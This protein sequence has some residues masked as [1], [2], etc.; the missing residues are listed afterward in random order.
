MKRVYDFLARLQENNN[1]EWFNLHKEEYIEAQTIFNDFTQKLIDAISRW[2]DEIR[3]SALTVKDCTYRIYRDTRFSKNK[4]PYKTHMGAYICK[5]GKKSPYAGYYFHLEP[6]SRQVGFAGFLGG[7]LLAAGLYC[8]DAKVIESIRDEISVNGDSFLDAIEE[9]GGFQLE[10]YSTLKRIPKGYENIEERWKELIKHKDFSIAEPLP[11]DM[12]ASGKLLEH[13][14][15]RFQKCQKFNS[16]LNLAVDY[17]Y[18][19]DF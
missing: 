14:I 18:D 5:K 13:I 17:A 9:T 3:D 15:S 1:R 10:N 16:I 4:E 6:T 12:L 7:S 19:Q 11:S 2:D 8:P